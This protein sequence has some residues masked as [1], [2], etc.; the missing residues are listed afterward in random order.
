MG[1]PADSGHH[2]HFQYFERNVR[3]DFEVV[4]DIG[5]SEYLYTARS[6]VRKDCDIWS[7]SLSY[8]MRTVAAYIRR[9]HRA[10]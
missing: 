6:E 8:R 9:G 1:H 2:T 5:H 3:K 10:F 7:L 4:H